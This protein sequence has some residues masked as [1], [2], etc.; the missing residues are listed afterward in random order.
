MSTDHVILNHLD[1]PSRILFWPISEFMTVAAPL[2][3]LVIMGHPFIGFTIAAVLVWIMRLF[4]KTFGKG[5]L[6]GV[7][8]WNFIHNKTNYPITP[9]SYIREYIG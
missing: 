5:T 1:A 2:V 4:K 7:L 6:E 9:P 8:Y 3:I